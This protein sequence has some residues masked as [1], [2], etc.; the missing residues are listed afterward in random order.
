MRKCVQAIGANS[1]SRDTLRR[2][3]ASSA[4]YW[5]LRLDA[6][7]RDLQ[8]VLNL[9]WD[10]LNIKIYL[11]GVVSVMHHFILARRVRT[12]GMLTRVTHA[13]ADEK[14][15]YRVGR[16]LLALLANEL[17]EHASTC[18]TAT[19]PTL[20]AAQRAKMIVDDLADR[21]ADDKLLVARRFGHLRARSF[22][23]FYVLTLVEVEAGVGRAQLLRLLRAL[24]HSMM[25]FRV[26]GH[27]NCE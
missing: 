25:L 24:K 2:L 11:S 23:R 18:I 8:V 26:T 15:P 10:N 4:N 16:R 6:L 9:L 19:R 17:M 12:R 3:F 27:D 14:I 1:V 13:C 21:D 20:T 7:L 22:V 5:Q